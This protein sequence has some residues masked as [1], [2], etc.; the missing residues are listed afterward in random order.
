MTFLF[1]LSSARKTGA[2]RIEVII[3][4]G[5][6]DG[7]MIKR[8][9]ISDNRRII[10]PKRVEIGMRCL[11]FGP[12]ISRAKCGDIRPTKPIIPQKET[13]IAVKTDAPKR[14]ISRF[15]RILSP[16]E[17]AVLSS[18]RSKSREVA[19]FFKKRKAMMQATKRTRARGQ[20]EALRL[21]MVQKITLSIWCFPR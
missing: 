13:T 11:C 17:T 20:D 5:S 6:S 16:L 4:I 19:S 18:I 8:A 3:P 14:S 1:L 10:A 7:A 2:P 12:I 21:P 9:R 15:F